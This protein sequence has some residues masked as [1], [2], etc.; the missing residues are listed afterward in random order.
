MAEERCDGNCE[1]CDLVTNPNLCDGGK[2]G[3]GMDLSLLEEEA[4]G[5]KLVRA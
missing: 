5:Y 2:Y 4:P 3:K 1:E